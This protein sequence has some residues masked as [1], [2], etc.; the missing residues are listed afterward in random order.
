M[1]F[2]DQVMS[3]VPTGED[4]PLCAPWAFLIQ[5]QGDCS[6]GFRPSRIVPIQVTSGPI[7]HCEETHHRIARFGVVY[8]TL[9]PPPVTG[10]MNHTKL[11]SD[12]LNSSDSTLGDWHASPLL[13]AAMLDMPFPKF[14]GS[15]PRPWI[16]HYETFFDVYRVDPRLWIHYS[17]MHLTSSVALWFQTLQSTLNTMTWAD[18]IATVSARFDRDEHNNLLRQFFHILPLTNV[19]VDIS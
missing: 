11:H 19:H 18:F 17:T 12:K 7:G 3:P 5:G 6:V 15:N 2:S 13:S 1:L 8:T 9:D 10:A 16:K 14:D 4:R